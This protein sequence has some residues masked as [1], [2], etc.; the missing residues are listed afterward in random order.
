MDARVKA[1][2]HSSNES[3]PFILKAKA[4]LTIGVRE[5]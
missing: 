5:W 4:D 1:R 3:F 2:K